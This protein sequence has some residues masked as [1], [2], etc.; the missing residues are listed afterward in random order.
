MDS[1]HATGCLAAIIKY[2]DVSTDFMY[3]TYLLTC[4][5]FSFCPRMLMRPA[6]CEAEG[7]DEARYHEVEAKAKKICEA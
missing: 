3:F 6:K 2:L 4:S 1:V 5:L 7:K